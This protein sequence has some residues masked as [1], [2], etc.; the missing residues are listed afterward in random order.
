MKKVLCLLLVGIMVV[1]MV[2]TAFATTN[3][4]NGTDVEYNAADDD[5]IG[6]IN[7]DGH[8]DNT[9]YYTVTVPALMAPGTS[10]NVVAKGTWASNRKLVVT[11]DE[12]VTLEN[13]IKAAD[14]KVLDI[15]F[16]GIELAGSNTAAV[17]D[18]KAVSVAGIDNALFGT[19]SGTF[20]YDVEMVDNVKM[21][22]FNITEITDWAYTST[23]TF[24][25]SAAEGSTWR[26]FLDANGGSVAID[27]GYL[28]IGGSSDLDENGNIVYSI[29]AGGGMYHLT[30]NEYGDIY[31]NDV[32]VDGATYSFWR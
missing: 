15:T 16:P 26:E 21:I 1:S 17:T 24:Q 30:H 12:T 23:T 2:P 9:E 20:Y 3:Y 19:W 31:E 22:T 11:A 29:G 4:T 6:D 32:I 28:E 13:S 10:G 18:T 27:W 5:T 7:G 14:Q 25:F 8:P